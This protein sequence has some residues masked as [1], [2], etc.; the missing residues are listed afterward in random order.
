[1]PFPVNVYIFFAYLLVIS[2]I[3]VVLTV[4]D[5]RRAQAGRWRVPEATLLLFSILGGSVAMLI[6]MKKI[7]HKTKKVKFM[8]GIPLILIAQVI[9]IAFLWVRQIICFTF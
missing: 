2:L 7:R 5:K 4:V 8:V 6:T 1:M 3:S 9:L